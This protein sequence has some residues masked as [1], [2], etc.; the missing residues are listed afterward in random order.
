MKRLHC[1]YCVGLAWFSAIVLMMH[2][3][4]LH[5]EHRISEHFTE[6]VAKG[7]HAGRQSSCCVLSS[8]ASKANHICTAAST[9]HQD[10]FVI[11]I[12]SVNNSSSFALMC[13]I[14]L[15]NF[16][17]PFLDLSPGWKHVESIDFP[18][19]NIPV[20]LYEISIFWPLNQK[21]QLLSLL[22]GASVLH[23]GWKIALSQQ[24]PGC[25]AFS[26]VVSSLSCGCTL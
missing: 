18:A 17:G 11:L 24:T 9:D 22:P 6:A 16:T 4:V 5:K 1:S 12:Q 21:G 20:P 19:I 8:Q 25:Y 13:I 10:F 15:Y 23:R 26:E 14:E 3:T 2:Q 7:L